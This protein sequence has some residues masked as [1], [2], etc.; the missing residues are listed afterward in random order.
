MIL[1]MWIHLLLPTAICD[2][3]QLGI[4]YLAIIYSSCLYHQLLFTLCCTFCHWHLVITDIL[5]G[6]VGFFN[7]YNL[8]HIRTINWEEIL[9]GAKAKTI[10][11]YDFKQPERECPPCDSSCEDGCWGEGAHNCQKFSKI[12]CSP[13]CHQGRCF[14]SEPRQ[15]CHL[16][17]A[18][19][20]TGPKQSDCLVSIMPF[21]PRPM[22][23]PPP[24]AP[25]FLAFS[26][27][28]NWLHLFVPANYGPNGGDVWAATTGN[29][30]MVQVKFN[31]FT[32]S[33]GPWWDVKV[34]YCPLAR[35]RHMC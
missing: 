13:Q 30:P 35:R 33:H 29:W 15:C 5:A 9:T 18:G 31:F 16:F 12:N 25:L 14:G 24:L 28:P 7:N 19:G 4:I 3:I 26:Y 1:Y 11:V 34:F 32:A 17:C 23:F 2:Q 10:Y 6:S 27:C 22:N 20:C 8:C 21:I